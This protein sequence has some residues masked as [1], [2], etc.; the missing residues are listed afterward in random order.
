MR[1]TEEQVIQSL[2]NM[3][4]RY[5]PLMINSLAEQVSLPEGS[6]VDAVIE[7][8]IQK[9]PSV[10]AVAEISHLGLQ[11]HALGTIKEIAICRTPVR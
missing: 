1:L 6:Q 2:K 7:F 9:G 11:E 4:E 5:S 3:G 8:S 10:K